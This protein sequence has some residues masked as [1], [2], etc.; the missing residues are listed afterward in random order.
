MSDSIDRLGRR[1]GQ[2]LRAIAR[3]LLAHKPGGHL[4][5]SKLTGL[6][7]HLRMGLGEEEASAGPFSREL[8]DSL[9]R[10]LDDAIQQAAVFRPGHAYCHRCRNAAC[11]HSLP[12]SGRHVFSGYQPTG[13]PR[14]LDFGQ[15]CLDTRHPG[16]DRLYDRP[17]A[18]L[19][20]VH[21]RGEL[22]GGILDA[23]KNRRYELLGQV[24]AGF[25]SVAAP[26]EGRREV[27][28]LTIQAAASHNQRGA[29]RFG[30]NLIGRAPGGEVLAM[31]WERQRE[32]PWRK[33]LL[34]AQSA[35]STLPANGRRGRS[36]MEQPE[37][38]VSGI[39][40]GLARRLESDR[41][42]RARRTDHAQERH[43]SGERPT[44]KALDDAR[45]VASDALLVDERSG[46]LVVL[47]DHGRTHF[48][49]P[50]GRLVSSVRY[51]KEAVARKIQ[52]E[53]WRPAPREVHRSFVE[54]LADVLG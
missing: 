45:A 26:A 41:R 9:D 40:R 18:L 10:Q 44:R 39:L 11:D 21:E 30:L 20:L 23:F 7:L 13:M 34:W 37:E 36:P 42:A 27:L 3:E 48:F 35:L 49:S 38:R 4:I 24:T 25:Y 43:A 53:V 32:L 28:A 15:L 14:W 51:S 17:P 2:A 54:K 5:E 52:A 22:H 50:E 19:T 6:D 33:A 29:T 8:I 1:A 46:T 12:P 16:V 47:G 31:L